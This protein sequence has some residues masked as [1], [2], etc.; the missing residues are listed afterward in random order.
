LAEVEDEPDP[1]CSRVNQLAHADLDAV[2]WLH[3]DVVQRWRLVTVSPPDGA[4]R[5]PRHPTKVRGLLREIQD[6]ALDADLHQMTGKPFPIAERGRV[7]V[8]Q[9]IAFRLGNR[10]GL[11]R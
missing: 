4:E 2:E 3:P 10:S 8:T 7:E 9:V 11:S 1:L 6:D 5:V